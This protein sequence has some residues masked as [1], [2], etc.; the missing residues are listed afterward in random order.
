MV[1]DKLVIITI[2]LTVLVSGCAGIDVQSNTTSTA[3]G[4]TDI[5]STTDDPEEVTTTYGSG[6]RLVIEDY[7]PK[8]F[9]VRVRYSNTNDLI[10]DQTFNNTGHGTIDLSSEIPAD[11]IVTIQITSGNETLWDKRIAPSEAY[12]LKILENGTIDE[13]L[14]E[15]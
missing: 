4:G 5:Q 15:S 11:E 1:P 2:C 6:F 12:T 8:P 9:D 3:E 10:I 14:Y 7:Y 13:V